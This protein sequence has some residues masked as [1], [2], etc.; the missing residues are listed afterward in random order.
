MLQ[1]TPDLQ[2]T[3]TYQQFMLRPVMA[4]D[5]ELVYAAASDPVIW[6]M[7]PEWER[8]KR[9]VFLEGYWNGALQCKSA[10]VIVENKE[11][12]IVGCT[13]YYNWQPKEQ[14]ICIG[15]TFLVRRYWGTAANTI[16]KHLMLRHIYQWAEI[17]E[18]E[19]GIHNLRSRRAVEKLGALYSR[20]VDLLV[21]NKSVPHVVYQLRK[22][23]FRS[24]V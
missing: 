21:N 4:A 9:D 24:S 8:Y 19:V 10:L 14:T 16:V 22:V 11:D 18:F 3:L 23:Q 6:S 15:Y 2:P 12:Q 7:H 20:T 5:E 1:T 13:R 17:V